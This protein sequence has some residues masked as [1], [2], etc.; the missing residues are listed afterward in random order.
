MKL[1]QNAA[2]ELSELGKSGKTQGHRDDL[3]SESLMPEYLP[4]VLRQ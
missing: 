3:M 1:G 4:C 2:N